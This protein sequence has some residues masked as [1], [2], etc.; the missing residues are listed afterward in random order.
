MKKTKLTRIISLALALLMTLSLAACG[1]DKENNGQNG[2]GNV[3]ADGYV[4]VPEYLSLDAEFNSINQVCYT[5]GHIYFSAYGVIGRAEP[6]DVTDPGIVIPYKGIDDAVE[7]TEAAAEDEAVAGAEDAAQSGDAIEMPVEEWDGM[8]D[9]YGTILYRANLDGTGVEKLEQYEPPQVPE[10]LLGSVNLNYMTADA[11][12][13]LWVC[14]SGWF[15]HY[16]LPEGWDPGQGNQWEYY[17]DDGQETYIRKLD[18][19]GAEITRLDISS[20]AQEMEYFYVNSMQVDD[21]GNIFIC[22][23]MNVY[24]L[25]PDG[26]TLFTLE[27]PEYV[28]NLVLLGNGKVGAMSWDTA[29]GK[30]VLKPIEVA[31]KSWGQDMPLP[32]NVY[33][34]YNGDSQYAFYYSDSSNFYGYNLETGEGEKLLNWIGCDINQNDLMAVVPMEDGRIICFT[35]S[36][37]YEGQGNVEIALLSKKP[38]SEVEQK[39]ILTLACMYLDYDLRGEI[40]KFNK[41]NGKYRIEVNDYS[42]YN[43]EED[44]YAGLTKLTTEITSGQVPDLLCT[45]QLPVKQYAAKGL[46]EDLYPYIDADP[47]LGRN[48][49][50]ESV[51]KAMEIGGKLYETASNFAIQTVVGNSSVVGKEMGWTLDEANELLKAH[52]GANLLDYYMT[53]ESVLSEFCAMSMA[54][55]VDWQTGKCSFDSDGFIKLLEF[56]K[57]FPEEYVLDED[58]YVSPAEMIMS[59]KQLCSILYV[60]DFEQ[61]QMYKAMFGG[62]ITFKGYPTESR[63]GNVVN[64]SSGI[65]MSSKCV[66]KEGAWEFMRLQFT[67]EYQAKRRYWNFPTNKAVFN[68]KLEEAM[69]QEYYIDENGEKKP[70]SRGSWGWDDL[71]VE[72]YAIT[73]EEADMI[74][75]L[76]NSAERTASYDESIMEIIRDE[77]AAFFAGQKSAKETAAV[78]QSRVNIYVNEQI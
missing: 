72:I 32:M 26:Q 25:G 14:E 23:E 29:T 42:E 11:E 60:G 76:I 28:Y 57:T 54:D 56:V 77:A 78:I 64:V 58:N 8:Y 36:W 2:N 53:R 21:A 46:L 13:N 63:K 17:V 34:I 40:I 20:L 6:G 39:T 61:F 30:Q 65:A 71:T 73:Q 69:K 31:T 7:E 66:D 10:G 22:F 9:I 62:D 18:A 59:G 1:G 35:Y 5:G 33:N 3:T 47:E 44:W 68:A 27:A 55:Y 12:G 16:E 67:E 24:V 15:Y 50:M 70:V 52:P 49:L 48:A 43:T 41:T 37:N 19:N 51:L 45:N 4:Y 75:D 38:A 74:M